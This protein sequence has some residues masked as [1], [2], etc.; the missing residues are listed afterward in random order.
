M[1]DKLKVTSGEITQLIK[2]LGHMQDTLES[3]IT[4]LNAVIDSVEGHWKGVAANAYNGLQSQVNLDVR[5]LKEI[6]AF[7]HEAVQMSRDGFDAE[8]VERLNSFKGID[9]VD[10]TGSNG[11]LDRFQVSQ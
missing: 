5:G 7:T 11:I 1:G 2:D 9:G 8:E 4:A 10:H 3:R 6:L